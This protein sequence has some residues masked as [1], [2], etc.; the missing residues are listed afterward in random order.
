MKIIDKVKTDDLNDEQK[1]LL[2][3]LISK[4]MIKKIETAVLTNNVGV[5]ETIKSLIQ[6]EKDNTNE[7]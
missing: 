7:K 2:S 5:V 3:E 1:R 6:G 4:E